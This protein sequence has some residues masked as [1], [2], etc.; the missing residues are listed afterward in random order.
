MTEIIE[1]LLD[2]PTTV[3]RAPDVTPEV[4]VRYLEANDYIQHGDNILANGHENAFSYYIHISDTEADG[5]WIP[6]RNDL[7]DW[8]ARC[9]DAM[10]DMA[11]SMGKT[12]LRVWYELTVLARDDTGA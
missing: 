2:L 3:H 7:N 8:R 4:M 9:L 12:Q 10:R 6:L 5:V 11:S 1:E